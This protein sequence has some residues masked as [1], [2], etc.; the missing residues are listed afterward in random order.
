MCTVTYIPLKNGFVLTSSRDEKVVR[1]TLKP[2]LYNHSNGSVLI[3]PKDEIAGGTWIAMDNN[4]KIACLLNGGYIN[5]EK[6]HIYSKSRGL[7][8]LDFFERMNISDFI[9]TINLEDVEPFTLLLIDHQNGFEFKELVW[10]GR[11]KHVGSNE[12]IAARIWSSSTLYSENDRILR[13]SW[14]REWMNKNEQQEDFNILNFHAVKHS[15][16]CENDIL[17]NRNDT[18]K[19][20]SISQIRVINNEFTFLYQDL[21]DKS[22]S[23][24]NL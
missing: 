17:M 21:L 4:K 6:L 3:Y 12:S 16:N 18:L 10:D 1:P 2:T 7:V 14:F 23:V 24:I 8:L 19:T 9:T 20:V 15:D 22:I 5:H 13:D 11:V